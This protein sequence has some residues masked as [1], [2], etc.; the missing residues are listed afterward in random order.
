MSSDAEQNGN[1][2]GS[3]NKEI[4]VVLRNEKGTESYSKVIFDQ[5]KIEEL[6]T[7]IAKVWF[8][9]GKDDPNISIIKVTPTTAYYWD[10][11]ESKMIN[12]LKMV[13]S[14]VTGTNVD[15]GNQGALII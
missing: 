5:E 2:L 4:L 6:W 15:I 10:T 14:V 9:E 13:A 8:I 1:L 11:D 7:P 12:F 3:E